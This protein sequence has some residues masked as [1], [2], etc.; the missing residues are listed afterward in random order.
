M[1]NFLVCGDLHKE[2]LD[3]NQKLMKDKND[4]KNK[5]LGVE[6]QLQEK[7]EQKEFNENNKIKI[8][9]ELNILK[10]ENMNLVTKNEELENKL[11]NLNKHTEHIL[12]SF[13]KI[14]GILDN[15]D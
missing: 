12:S 4:L 9:K 6:R 3:K 7:K 2:Q 14:N 11:C 13:K 8:K 15:Y 10:T 1:G 5:V